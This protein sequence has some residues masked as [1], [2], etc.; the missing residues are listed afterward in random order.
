MNLRG[1]KILI[2]GGAGGIG[3]VLVKKVVEKQGSVIVFDCVQ[4]SL[5][6][7]KQE[8]PTIHCCN[9]N[10]T[11][12]K[13]IN[14]VVED[15][16]NRLEGIDVLINNAAFVYNSMLIHFTADG[17]IQHD[18]DMWNK[19]IATDLNSVFYMTR[20]VAA[21]MVKRRTKGVIVNVSSVCSAGNPGQ[22]AYS[23]AK[24]GVNALTVAWAG[25]LG[26]LGIRVVAVA[27]GYADT[28]RTCQSMNETVLKEWKRKTPLRRLGKPEEIA[29]GII[30]CIENDFINGT[31][32]EINGGLRI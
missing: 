17:I 3:Q 27:P 30:F 12:P 16:D 32:L 31:V 20:E 28:G 26:L 23:A 6:A 11:D 10:I 9:V 24:A 22:S 29:D 14:E 19:I 13:K 4:E 15:I 1:K 7:L 5:D 8:Y 25:E 2:T 21:K 18:V